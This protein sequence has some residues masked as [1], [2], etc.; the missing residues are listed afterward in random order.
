MFGCVYYAA[1]SF[2][3]P[4]S[5]YKCVANGVEFGIK[6]IFLSFFISK[7]VSNFLSYIIV[8]EIWGFRKCPKLLGHPVYSQPKNSSGTVPKPND[9][10]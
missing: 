7:Y 5:M 10:G 4:I 9:T 3:L 1:K 8:L 6:I 2:S